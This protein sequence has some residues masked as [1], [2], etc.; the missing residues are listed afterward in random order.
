MHEIEFFL[1]FVGKFNQAGFRYFVTGS[2]AAMLYGEPRLTQ[3]IDI[4]LEVSNRDIA[5][6]PRIFPEADYYCP[7]LEVLQVENSRRQRGHFNIIHLSSGHKA[8]IYLCGEDQLHAWAFGHAR[9][10]P[11]RGEEIWVAAPEYVI[12]RKLEFF[13]E[14]GSEKHLRDIKSMLAVSQKLI[15]FS[16]LEARIQYWGL[17]EQWGRVKRG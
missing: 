16:E 10:I 2:V 6:L 12:I 5:E 15:D 9:K 4:V 11:F 13:R 1:P 17:A 3:D 8:D 14:G 7:P